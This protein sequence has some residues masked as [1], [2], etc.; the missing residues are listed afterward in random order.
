[1]ARPVATDFIHSMRFQVVVDTG[2]RGISLSPE[3]RADA[4]FS[5]ATVPEVTTEAVEYREGTMV[6]TRKYPGLPTMNDISLSRGVARRD[7]TFWDWMRR[8]VEGSGEYRVDLSI[9]H[10]HRDTAL[11]RTTPVVDAVNLTAINIDTPAK[12][13]L[14]KEAFPIRHKVAGDL[15]ATASEISI[16]EL[17]V[18]FEYFEVL[19]GVTP[20]A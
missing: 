19:Q 8:V 4:G 1:M 2:D 5:M 20:G 16:Q 11:V 15:D 9:R 10:F 3:G 13:Y 6:Y 18:A 14:I 7:S 12:T 17:D